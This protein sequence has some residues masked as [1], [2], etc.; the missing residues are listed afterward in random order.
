MNADL[1]RERKSATFDP[2]ELSAV[3]YGGRERLQQKRHLV[4]LFQSDRTFDGPDARFLSRQEHV[5]ESLRKQVYLIQKC[6]QLGL[7]SMEEVSIVNNAVLDAGI[8]PLSLHYAAFVPPIR[9]MADEQQK[10]KWLGPAE[11]CEII[12]CYAQTE[13]GHGSFVRGIETRADY[14]EKTKQFVLNT[15]TITATKWWVGSLGVVA[16]H[17][18]LMA[19]L[20]TQGKPRGLHPFIVQIRSTDTHKPMPGVIVGDIGPKFGFATVD[21]GFL[22]LKDVRIPKD[23]ML[24]KAGQVLDDG[25]YVKPK[26]AKLVYGGMLGIRASLPRLAAHNIAKATVIAIR[27]SSVRRQ[28]ELKPG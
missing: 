27:Y 3:L 10:Q 21:N 18:I 22:R 11:R 19:Q 20:Y 7:E 26:S 6:Q 28:S 12:G 17:A 9:L 15:P 8:G 13:L 1:E 25:T 14:D 23:Q 4:H 2:E 16:T 24:T 5:A